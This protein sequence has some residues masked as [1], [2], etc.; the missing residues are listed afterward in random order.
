[1]I[2]GSDR[3]FCTA[4]LGAC[5]PPMPQEPPGPPPPP[6]L[7]NRYSDPALQDSYARLVAAMRQKAIPVYGNIFSQDDAD[8]MARYLLDAVRG[9]PQSRELQ[10][11]ARCAIQPIIMPYVIGIGVGV[12]GAIG[13]SVLALLRS[14]RA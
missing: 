8:V 1:M 6:A 3:P 7:Y 11:R 4:G 10:E 13:L 12:A 2:F 5:P 9:L 14:R